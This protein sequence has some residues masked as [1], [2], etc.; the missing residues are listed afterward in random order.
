MYGKL[1]SKLKLVTDNLLF[2]SAEPTENPLEVYTCTNDHVTTIIYVMMAS[3]ELYTTLLTCVLLVAYPDEIYMQS[4][5]KA[6][7]ISPQNDMSCTYKKVLHKIIKVNAHIKFDDEE[8]PHCW[9]IFTTARYEEDEKTLL[10]LFPSEKVILKVLQTKKI[11][12]AP[13]QVNLVIESWRCFVPK[14]RK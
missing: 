10:F 9:K 13:I 7:Y 5:N 6:R 3:H 1:F 2:I 8:R 12:I 14:I 4:N 11:P